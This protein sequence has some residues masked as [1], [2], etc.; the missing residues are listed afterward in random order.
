MVLEDDLYVVTD[1]VVMI[2]AARVP[3]WQGVGSTQPGLISAKP[4]NRC[5]VTRYGII[6]IMQFEG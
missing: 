4:R 3:G 2:P 1:T 5:A 6:A